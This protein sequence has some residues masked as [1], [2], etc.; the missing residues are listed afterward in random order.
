MQ[1][2]KQKLPREQKLCENEIA[3]IEVPDMSAVFYS[4]LRMPSHKNTMRVNCTIVQ[5]AER[6]REILRGKKR[7]ERIKAKSGAPETDV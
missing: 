6:H 2:R 1:M 5:D 4:V 3:T 7:K